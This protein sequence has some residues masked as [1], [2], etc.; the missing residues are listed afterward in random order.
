[1]KREAKYIATVSLGVMGAGFLATLPTPVSST[2]WGTF[3]QG[4]FEAGVVGGLADWFAVSALFRHPLG[5]PIP[6]TALLPKNRE[7][8]TKA[9][10][11]TVENELLSKETI[12]TR[13]QQIRF[14]ERGLELAETHL[15]NEALHKGLSTL[16]KQALNA[17]DL[18]KLTPLL[19]EEIH[20]AL[21][22]LDT[23]RLVRTI[24]D[25]IAH[26]GYDGKT[27]DFVIDKVEAW[28][29]KADTRDQLGAM[30]LKAFEG[31][32]S[33]GFMAF[34]VNA[35]I[36]MVNEEKIGGIIQ[37]FVLSYIEQMR[38]KNHPRREAVLTFIRNELNKLERN[39]QLL[40][41]LEGLK[42]KLPGLFDL[43][44]KLSGLLERL[45]AKAEDFVDQPDFVP[46]HVVP[47]VRKML[48]SVK[49]NEDMLQ[50]GESWIQEQIAA[51]LEQNHSKIGLLVKEN[52]DKLTNDKLTQ[53]MEDKLGND[54]QWIRVN[55]AICGFIIGLG[56]AGLKM[57]F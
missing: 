11:S 40:A 10:V 9:L 14:L 22:D 19:A 38:T 34:A 23:S 37:N 13:L 17:I 5:I 7:K 30:A 57:L 2:I 44:E 20:K 21:Q 28:A 48:I 31:L 1:M 29:I 15:D 12:R 3:L 32:Q 43:D 25:S 33:N 45:K 41:E 50:R 16:A 52:L 27:F 53:L 26:G 54:L 35:F 6:H 49:E 24:V 18:N 51:Y 39:P 47:V 55:G 36:G 8:I 4:G 46:Q 56:L 42:A